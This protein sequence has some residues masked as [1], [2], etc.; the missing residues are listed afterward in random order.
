[1]LWAANASLESRDFKDI[2]SLPKTSG[3]LNLLQLHPAKTHTS[4]KGNRRNWLI[5]D[6]L[7]KKLKI[8]IE[9]GLEL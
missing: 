5:K 2:Y 3:A 4:G 7:L 6:F 8:V 1:M 9:L